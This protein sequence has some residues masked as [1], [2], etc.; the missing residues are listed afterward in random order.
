MRAIQIQGGK[1]KHSPLRQINSD[2]R[3][4][5]FFIAINSDDYSSIKNKLI[6]YLGRLIILWQKLKVLH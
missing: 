3:D 2:V 5:C 6:L 4:E 1:A